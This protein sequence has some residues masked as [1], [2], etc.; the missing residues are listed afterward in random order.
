MTT[1]HT[2]LEDRLSALLREQA[3]SVP[4]DEVTWAD[5]R[6][7]SAK[8]TRPPARTGALAVTAVAALVAVALGT[9]LLLPGDRADRLATGPANETEVPPATA[10][11]PARFSVATR[12]VALDAA[13]VT[14]DAGGRTFAAAGRIQVVSDPGMA[15][16]YTTLELTWRE[17]DVEM[18]LFLYFASDGREWWAS[19]IRTYDGSPEGDWIVYPGEHFRRPLGTQFT[20][21]VELVAPLPAAGRLV[22]KDLHVRPFLTPPEC[23]AATTSLVLDPGVSG[24]AIPPEASGYGLR[25][26]LL[27]AAS[28]SPVRDGDRYRY[29]WTPT[30]PGVVRVEN[31][32]DPDTRTAPRVDL[33]PEGPGRTTLR[34]TA[35]DADTGAVV[36]RT[37]VEV[38]VDERDPTWSPPSTGSAP[39][40]PPAPPAG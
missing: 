23:A 31:H 21:D 15:N 17:H 16:E 28:C 13:A 33:V 27:D 8:S 39:P 10:T 4:V 18:R 9:A 22:L 35:T 1:P 38:V 12:Q 7:V 30:E 29:D 20:G 2:R 37:D 32:L 11:D 14:I 19:E 26:R 24:V 40:A 34:V 5:V 6:L 3:A 36:A 25:V